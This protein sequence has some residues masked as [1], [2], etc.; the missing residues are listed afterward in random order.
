MSLKR[1]AYEA[2]TFLSQ[3]GWDGHLGTRG[4]SAYLRL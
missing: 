4:L 1:D 2:D 3:H